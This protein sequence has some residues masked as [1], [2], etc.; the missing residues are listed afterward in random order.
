[1][2]MFCYLIISLHLFSY[3]SKICE[4]SSSL[5]CLRSPDPYRQLSFYLEGG[6]LVQ[7]V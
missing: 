6:E 4:A 1:M 7:C 5:W 3:H 2:L